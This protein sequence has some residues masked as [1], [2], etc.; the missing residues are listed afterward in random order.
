MYACLLRNYYLLVVILPTPWNGQAQLTWLVDWLTVKMV[1][2]RRERER[3]NVNIV[4]PSTN[5]A[6]RRATNYTY[7]DQDQRATAMPDQRLKSPPNEII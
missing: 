7:V 5:R 6:G 4:H 2:M 3:R 1:R